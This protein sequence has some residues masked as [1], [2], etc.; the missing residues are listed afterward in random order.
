MEAR[1]AV[2]MLKSP[3]ARAALSFLLSRYLKI[4]FRLQLGLRLQGQQNLRLLAEDKPVIVAFWHEALPLAPILWNEAGKLGMK[5]PAV[6]LI[7]RHRDGQMI[8]SILQRFGIGMVSGSSSKGGVASTRELTKSLQNGLNIGLTPDGPRGP[9]R[10]AAAGVAALAGIS[11]AQILPCG[12]ATT[13]FFVIKKSWD[14]MR[15]PLPLGRMVLV[16]D[17]PIS[18]PRDTWRDALPD[19]EAALNDAQKQAM[20]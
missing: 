18:V 7:S 3:Q 5:R 12:I 9:A 10:R 14:K 20:V 15:V 11:G 6:A 17:T 4:T 19:I 1:G 8:G 13:R 2:S 16:C